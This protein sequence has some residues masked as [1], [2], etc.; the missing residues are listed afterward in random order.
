[1]LLYSTRELLL[2]FVYSTGEGVPGNQDSVA[3]RIR[4][5]LFC[6]PACSFALTW[7]SVGAQSKSEGIAAHE[8]PDY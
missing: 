5:G 6:R 4:S 2:V 1:M 3:G 8:Q 7:A